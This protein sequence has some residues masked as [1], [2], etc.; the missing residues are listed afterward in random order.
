M[1]NF[2][3]HL[4]FSTVLSG[5]ACTMLLQQGALSGRDAFLCWAAGSLGGILPDIDSNN[6]HSLS[7][8]FW[9]LSF[10]AAA[11]S[12]L[13]TV[14]HLS[15]V[16]VWLVCCGVF[17]FVHYP[18][19]ALFE[20]LTVHRG[21]FHSLVAASATG[22]AMVC[23]LYYCGVTPSLSWFIGGFVSFGYVLHLILDEVYSVDFAGAYIKRSFGTALKPLDKSNW[24][25]SALFI[26]VCAGLFYLSPPYQYATS[27]LLNSLQGLI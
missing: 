23:G 9:V 21:I 15:L 8:L 19:R 10:A 2:K 18:I 22:L 17:L 12:T 5:M 3:T 1:A 25:V 16:G 14:Q 26:S 27:T 20:S 4:Q 7:I 13:Y 24:P 11:L 6:S